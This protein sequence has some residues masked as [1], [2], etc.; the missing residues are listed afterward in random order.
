MFSYNDVC[1][2]SVEEED[3]D[4][5]REL[6]NEQSTWM[7]LTTIGQITKTQQ[8]TW[9]DKISWDTSQIYY[10]A[11][12]VMNEFP[13][14]YAGEKVGIVR[15]DCIDRT[16]KNCRVGCDVFPIKRGNSWGTKIFSAILEL[17]FDYLN[18]HMVHLMV[19]EPNEIAQK[20]YRKAGLTYRGVLPEMV[21]RDGL[22]IDY[23]IMAITKDTYE[24]RK[25]K[26][27]V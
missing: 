20:I 16:N 3:L 25:T 7:N 4:E 6:R 27:S 10:V 17:C 22:Y 19:L 12:E 11:C 26:K 5:L 18:M 2:N 9:F 23:R 13:I 21:Y 8:R 1:F 24:N 15:I 14:Q